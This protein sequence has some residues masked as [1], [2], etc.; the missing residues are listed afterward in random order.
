VGAHGGLWYRQATGCIDA[1]INTLTDLL[2][3]VKAL[4][5]AKTG[6]DPDEPDFVDQDGTLWTRVEAV[7]FAKEKDAYSSRI[8]EMLAK[9]CQLKVT[10][11]AVS[12]ETVDEEDFIDEDGTLWT[13]EVGVGYPKQCEVYQRHID[14]LELSVK[15]LQASE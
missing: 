15:S 11:E 5:A 3:D 10:F 12:Q 13:R 1:R 8:D 9:Y 4:F 14:E 7:P 6:E 2:V